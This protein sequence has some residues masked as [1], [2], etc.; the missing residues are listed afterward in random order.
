MDAARLVFITHAQF[1]NIVYTSTDI[2]TRSFLVCGISACVDGT[3]D[4]NIH[5]LKSGGV[6]SEALPMITE[7]T[8]TLLSEAERQDDDERPLRRPRRLRGRVRNK[9]T[10]SRGLV[11][12]TCTDNSRSFL[13]T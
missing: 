12:N 11:N 13:I 4:A 5:C 10:A 7:N 3:E 1:S 9:R 8:A 2:I 6:A